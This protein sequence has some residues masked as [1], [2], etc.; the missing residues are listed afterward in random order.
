VS[1][2]AGASQPAGRCE[3]R[4]DVLSEAEGTTVSV[5][6]ATFCKA[7]LASH[8]P[9]ALRSYQFARMPDHGVRA[10][11]LPVELAACWKL[12]RCGNRLTG[13]DYDANV[14]PAATHLTGE[15]QAVR[16]E[17]CPE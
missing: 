12:V 2:M 11:G 3:H 17:L 10:V 16:R 8:G 1:P 5:T 7:A 14:R 13:N 6:H 9:G 15:R 4:F